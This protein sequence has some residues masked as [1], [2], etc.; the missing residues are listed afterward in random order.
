MIA[1]AE[2]FS[3]AKLNGAVLR[4]AVQGASGGGIKE[5]IYYR[6]YS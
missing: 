4:G 5:A 1:K 3:V 6:K 2:K